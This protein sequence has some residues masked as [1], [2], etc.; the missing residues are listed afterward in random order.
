MTTKSRPAE[1]D[2]KGGLV[3]IRQHLVL[4]A[5]VA[6]AV[7]RIWRD[8]VYPY[9][10]GVDARVYIDASRVW[11][12]GGD[13]WRTTY[14]L[15]VPFGAPPPALLVTAPFTLFPTQLGGLLIVLASALLAIAALRS[16]GLPLWWLLWAPLLDGLLVGSL[17]IAAMA[18][19]VLAS[20]R[21]LAPLMRIYAVVPMVGER[22]WR[23][24][25]IGLAIVAATI[26]LLPWAMFLNDLGWVGTFYRSRD[27]GEMMSMFSV[28]VLWVAMAL[29]LLTLGLRRASWLA[30]PL[31]A[32]FTHAHY[33]AMALPFVATSTLL[34][35]GF[36][37][38]WVV[39]LAPAAAVGIYILLALRD[40]HIG[41]IR[42]KFIPSPV[43]S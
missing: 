42:Q 15:G 16:L 40:R 34:T 17:D 37:W 21:I 32:P 14:E 29:G 41:T 39:P 1:A 20:G 3:Y 27:F 2:R 6:P 9:H 4:V 30:V 5:V 24:L 28:P 22:Q 38:C 13:P 36:A 8:I 19:L 31:L 26:P 43:N 10:F 7:I 33:A 11:L 35:V 18:C 23:D 12:A 25:A